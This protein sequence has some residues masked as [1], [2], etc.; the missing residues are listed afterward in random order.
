MSH[1]Y[2]EKLRLRFWRQVNKAGADECWLW[3]GSLSGKKYG[4]L[5]VAGRG[6]VTAHRYSY[7]L[8]IGP[9]PTGAS[10]IRTCVN[11]LCV[12]P[13][14]FRL[15]KSVSGQSAEDR[16]WEKVSKLGPKDCWLWRGGTSSKGYPRFRS[17]GKWIR[18]NRYSY[19]LHKGVIPRGLVARHT[20]HNKLCVNP[21]HLLVGSIS[22]N[23]RDTRIKNLS[24][25][26]ETLDVVPKQ[27]WFC[28]PYREGA[29][30]RCC[31][32]GC[33]GADHIQTYH[34][35]LCPQQP[36]AGVAAPALR[37]HIR[38]GNA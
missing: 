23:G 25:M 31:L 24:K 36:E 9:I 27:N 21:A 38:A 20:C 16:F 5:N 17:G 33:F 1:P 4:R 15:E 6:E 12:N 11:K 30:I 29:A 37:E 35:Y 19:T 32:C 2:A 22:D 8:H 10:V 26:V 3:T 18:V 28:H 14:H 34:G 7:E 13:K